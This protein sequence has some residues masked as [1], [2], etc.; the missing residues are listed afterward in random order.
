MC[1]AIVLPPEKEIEEDI[2]RACFIANSQGAGYGFYKD[3]DTPVIDKG[4]MTFKPFYEAFS[5]A[6]EENK[7]KTFLIHF[8]IR[9]HGAVSP[10]NC[11]PFQLDNAMLAHN[12]VCY[13]F[14]ELS[15]GKSD[16]FELADE[17]RDVHVD[18][19]EE[20]ANGITDIFNSSAFAF[21]TKTGKV[22]LAG[23]NKGRVSADGIWYSNDGWKWNY[24]RE[25]KKKLEESAP[26]VPAVVPDK[27]EWSDEDIAHAM[28]PYGRGGFD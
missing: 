7:D 9:T 8:R 2:L 20:L 28:I 23:T 25:K 13:G 3:P 4:Y 10:E 15:S 1:V 24:E 17:I 27:G 18:D 22:I 11:H 26:P 16:T 19:F 14:G 6:R 21:L 5:K 12:G